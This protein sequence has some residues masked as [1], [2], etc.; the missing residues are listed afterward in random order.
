MARATSL[1]GGCLA[2]IWADG[3][4]DIAKVVL[5]SSTGMVVSGALNPAGTLSRW[6]WIGPLNPSVRSAVTVTGTA[7]PR[8]MAGARG[9][10]L[11]EKSGRGGRIVSRYA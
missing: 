8:Q 4:A 6:T 2:G 11:T 10:K 7:P 3:A 1:S 9:L 5:F